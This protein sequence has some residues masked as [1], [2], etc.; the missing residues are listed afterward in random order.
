[1]KKILVT[2]GTGYIG[3]HTVVKLVESDY[4][5]II[6]DNLSNSKI[7]V[8][9]RIEKITNKRPLFI[10]GDIRDSLLLDKIMRDHSFDVVMHFAGLKAVAE[11][12]K[13]PLRY[14]DNN[15]VGSIK[16]FEAMQKANIKKIVFSS[17]ATAYG[18]SGVAQYK[19]DT[20]L[21]PINTYGHTKLMVEDILRGLKKSDSS[22]SI[23]ILRYFNPVGAHQSGLIGEDPEGIPNNLMPYISQVALGLREKLYIYGNDY[24]TPDGTGLRDYIHVVDLAEG[25]IAALNKLD[26]TPDLIIANLGTGRPLS[27]LDVLNMFAKI[28]NKKIPYVVTSRRSGDLAEYY[29]D[30]SLAKKIFN[31]SAQFDIEI[32]C[33]DAWRWQNVGNKII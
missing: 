29:A 16:L 14:F 9:D 28:S 22:W 3:S 2:G 30:P 19:E 18:D 5:V 15:V 25:H 21:K 26:V 20:P 33:I 23:A 32:M 8:I 10:K 31:W 4:E 7:S 1:M 24:P 12:E 13:E 17:S 11:S 27:V 6:L